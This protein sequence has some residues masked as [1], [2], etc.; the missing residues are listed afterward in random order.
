MSQVVLAKRYAKALFE[1]GQKKESAQAYASQLS[2]ISQAVNGNEEYKSFFE[3]TAVSKETK[4]D[5]LKKLFSSAKVDEEVQ[6][7]LLLLVDKSRFGILSY[8]VMANQEILD[9]QQ[10]TTRGVIK[11]SQAVSEA[12]K[13]EYEAK[14]SKIMNKKIQLETQTDATVLG[15]VRVEVGGWTFDDSLQTHLNQLS[16]KI[17]NT[18]F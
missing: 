6:A 4:K 2:S 17:L 7:F 16:D 14:I 12:L 10:G 11:S 1:L 9:S 8:I 3:S 5:L 18:T 13:K 15:G